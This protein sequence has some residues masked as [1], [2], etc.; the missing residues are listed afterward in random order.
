MGN[1]TLALPYIKTSYDVR[2]D[3]E[4]AKHLIAVYTALGQLGAARTI[5]VVTEKEL[6]NQVKQQ[7]LIGLTSLLLRMI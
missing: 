7:A 3:P 4:S 1:P 6:T 5:M 2:Y